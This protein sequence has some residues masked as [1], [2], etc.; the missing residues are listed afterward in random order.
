MT[1][2][3]FE[4]TPIPKE[5]IPTYIF[6]SEISYKCKYQDPMTMNSLTTMKVLN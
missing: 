6:I 3:I 2:L 1:Y 4:T 5:M